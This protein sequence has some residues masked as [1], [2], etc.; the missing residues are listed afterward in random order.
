MLMGFFPR[1]FLSYM[2]KSVDKF[3]ADYSAHVAEPDCIA[4]TYGDT[5]T[6]PASVPLAPPAPVVPAVA[7][8]GGTP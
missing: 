1:P 7:V 3:I 8:T 4:H 6:C 2:E 5:K